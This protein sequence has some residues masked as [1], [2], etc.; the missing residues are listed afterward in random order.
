[1]DGP[2][3][4][5]EKGEGKATRDTERETKRGSEKKREKEREN[6][7]FSGNSAGRKGTKH[8]EKRYTKAGF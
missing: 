4:L 5:P 3:A 7:G 2:P 1:M 8:K 6:L